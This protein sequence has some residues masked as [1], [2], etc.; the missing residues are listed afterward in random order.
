[1]SGRR[2]TDEDREQARR[3]RSRGASYEQIMARLGVSKGTLSYWLN[4]ESRERHLDRCAVVRATGVS[5]SLRFTPEA[6][7]RREWLKVLAADPCAYC[8]AVVPAG[9]VDH[10]V[11]TALDG[12]DTPENLTGACLKCNSSKCATPLLLFLQGQHPEEIMAA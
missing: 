4:Q 12:D 10:I 9:T 8:A 11:P 1:V 5:P 6:I 3:M 2:Y 7:E